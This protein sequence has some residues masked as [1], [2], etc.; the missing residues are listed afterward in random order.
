MTQLDVDVLCLGVTRKSGDEQGECLVG[1]RDR[2]K[3]FNIVIRLAQL[4]KR[5]LQ[6]FIY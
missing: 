2:T 1:L 3:T 4:H 5:H 6:A